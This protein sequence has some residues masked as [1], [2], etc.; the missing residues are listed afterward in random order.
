MALEFEIN[1]GDGVSEAAGSAAHQVSLLT[2]QMQGLQSAMIKANAMGDGDAFNKLASQ[3]QKLGDHVEGLGGQLK[4]AE[5]AA[6]SASMNM[7]G[8]G[9]AC[10]AAETAIMAAVA[11]LA[12][13]AV[14]AVAAGAAIAVA[15]GEQ[16]LALEATVAA[17]SKSA[18]EGEKV[19]DVLGRMTDEL[20][21]SK[22]R[23][24][25]LAKSFMSVGIR[26]APRLEKALKATAAATALL[27]ESAGAKISGLI[28]KIEL[29]S[30]AG[31]DL[32]NLSKALKGTGLD[33]E[34]VAKQLGKPAKELENLMKTGKITSAQLGD[35][36]QDAMI[37]K[38]ANAVEVANR[39]LGVMWDKMKAHMF[40]L[41]EGIVDTPGY[42]EFID[43]IKQIGM[44]FGANAEGMQKS[45]TGAFSKIF[46]ITAKVLTFMIVYGLKFATVLIRIY[47][48][49][50]PI[51]HWTMEAVRWFWKWYSALIQLIVTNNHFV[52][53]LKALGVVLLFIMSPFILIVA[54]GLLFIAAI[55]ALGVAIVWLCGLIIDKLGEAWDYMIDWAESGIDAASDFIDGIVTGIK[56]GAKWVLDAVKNLGKSAITGFKSM[57]GISSPSKVMMQMGVH[58][59]E[60]LETGLDTSQASVKASASK[61]GASAAEGVAGGG[62]GRGGKSGGG[63]NINITVEK[64]AIVIGGGG[65]KGQVEL[66]EEALS[67]LL[68]RVAM[69][70]G[71]LST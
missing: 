52:T 18:A 27:G 50:F 22:D 17:Y 19:L 10:A 70:S 5:P 40:D 31:K 71:L 9:E 21:L 59:G 65:E 16:R 47:I 33:A 44:L 4:A 2:K 3:Y 23:I 35:A 56:N 25:G 32:K 53:G 55:I 45:L 20:P 67:L 63:S 54:L 24:E 14:A 38:G 34:D 61:M 1:L 37:N 26:D 58:M 28:S 66:T 64:G 49:L 12:A 7:D 39:K 60:G 8:L 69:Q 29:L 13:L 15:E 48:A 46:S 43:V 36:I 51:I 11:A 41:F 30:E 42:K 62:N 57:L 68:E 6:H